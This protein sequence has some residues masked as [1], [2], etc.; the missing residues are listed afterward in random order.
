MRKL[1]MNKF[2]KTII[3]MLSIGLLSC[4]NE[5]DIKFHLDSINSRKY[6]SQEIIPDDYQKIYGKW[7]LKEISGGFS[8]TGYEPDYDYLEIKSVGIYGF[9]RNDSLFEYGK[10]EL[11]TFDEISPDYLQLSYLQ[12]RLIPDY[13]VGPYSYMDTPEKYIDLI[14][15]DSLVLISPCCDRYNYHYKRVK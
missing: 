9:I 8:G 15:N 11:D 7:K 6:Y 1:N 2:L 13:Y 4:E 3:L 12:V 5:N 10:I 14:G